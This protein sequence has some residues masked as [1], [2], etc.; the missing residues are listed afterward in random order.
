MN[1]SLFIFF[2]LALYVSENCAR[3]YG[4][5]FL[6]NE[7]L[8][9]TVICFPDYHRF[10]TESHADAEIDAGD[11]KHKLK[12]NKA[13]YEIVRKQQY[14]LLKLIG[15][16]EDKSYSVHILVEDKPSF[17]QNNIEIPKIP[18]VMPRY[19]GEA[20]PV[21]H[22]P[23]NFLKD[24]LC[25][26][27]KDPI[28]VELRNPFDKNSTINAMEQVNQE[29]DSKTIDILK[30]MYKDCN[31]DSTYDISVDASMINYIKNGDR[32]VIVIVAGGNHID[33]VSKILYQC[34][35]YTLTDAIIPEELDQM[36]R[37]SL[38]KFNEKK[39]FLGELQR[40]PPHLANLADVAFVQFE[41]LGT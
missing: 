27:N 1:N 14:E 40:L 39:P 38:I 17:L 6:R 7:Q 3:I 36:R 31:F 35:G 23:L 29:T 19:Q 37:E 2:I 25:A 5:V 21:W 9:K 18:G 41:N 26:N 8:G 30:L 33:V 13:E 16:L 24:F 4:S 11:G 28:N 10:I 22:S 15:M 12:I 20:T 32:Q 34:Y